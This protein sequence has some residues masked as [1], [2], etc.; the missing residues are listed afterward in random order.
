MVVSL[1]RAMLFKG[2]VSL[3]DRFTD[4]VGTYRKHSSDSELLSPRA[5]ILNFIVYV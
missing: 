1:E 3:K 5:N 2:G 4:S